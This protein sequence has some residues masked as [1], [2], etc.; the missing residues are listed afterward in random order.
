MTT[1]TLTPKT[2]D[3]VTHLAN[4]FLGWHFTGATF[5]DVYEGM[6][7]VRA[8]GWLPIIEADPL[9]EANTLWRMQLTKGGFP[10]IIIHDTDWFATDGTYCRLLTQD[11]VAADY[12][13]AAVA[14]S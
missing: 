12:T 4:P 9:D 7:V 3:P 8:T 10:A 14:G 1:Y 13:V 11:T 6:E 2:A 5:A